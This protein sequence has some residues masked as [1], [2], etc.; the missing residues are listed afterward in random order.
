MKQAIIHSIILIALFIS[1]NLF[2]WWLVFVLC[3]ICALLID[4]FFEIIAIG[5]FYDVQYHVPGMHWYATFINSAI[6]VGI[7][8]I[9]LFVQK[10]TRKPTFL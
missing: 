8:L 6:M 2:P 1:T 4:N 10:I 7:F 9:S 3:G 5:I